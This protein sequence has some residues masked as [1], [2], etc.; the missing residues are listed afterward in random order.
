M[1]D[2]S[3]VAG[4]PDWTQILAS[5]VMRT[6]LFTNQKLAL[7]NGLWLGLAPVCCTSLL[8]AIVEGDEPRPAKAPAVQG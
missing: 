6:Y 1:G 5:T 7:D 4:K 8:K 3:N 2:V